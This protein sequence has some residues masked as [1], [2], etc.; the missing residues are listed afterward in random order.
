MCTRTSNA[1]LSVM[2]ISL[3][4]S[5]RYSRSFRYSRMDPSASFGISSVL[6][7]AAALDWR[8]SASLSSCSVSML[9]APSVDSLLAEVSP[10]GAAVSGEMVGSVAARTALAA[11]T[12]SSAVATLSR[13]VA[14]DSADSPVSTLPHDSAAGEIVSLACTWCKLKLYTLD[15][16][17]AVAQHTESWSVESLCI[18]SREMSHLGDTLHRCSIT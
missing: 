7:A 8:R 10:L 11:A 3:K 13:F 15:V 1:Y 17:S 6:D 14:G 9:T 18:L 2:I 4:L 12:A 16:I 5:S